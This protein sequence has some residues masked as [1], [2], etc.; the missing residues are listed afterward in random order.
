MLA[1]EKHV[2]AKDL[3]A[4]KW[5]LTGV[6]GFVFVWIASLNLWSVIQ[7]VRVK[8]IGSMIPVTGGIAGLIAFVIAPLPVLRYLWYMPLFFDI[9]CIPLLIKTVVFL[10]RRWRK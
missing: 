2:R 10:L 5:I 7:S 4:M 9:G 6:F 3:Q 1:V 8:R